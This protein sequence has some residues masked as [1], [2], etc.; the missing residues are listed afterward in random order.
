MSSGCKNGQKSTKVNPV[1]STI[2]GERKRQ[3]ASRNPRI[4]GLSERK[5]ASSLGGWQGEHALF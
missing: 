3:E 5:R 1:N 4:P 2:A